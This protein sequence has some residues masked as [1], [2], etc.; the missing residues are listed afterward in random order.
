[1]SNITD[2]ELIAITNLTRLRLEFAILTRIKPGTTSEMEPHT[3]FSLLEQEYNSIM[4]NEPVDRAFFDLVNDQTLDAKKTPLYNDVAD[5]KKDAGIIY[6]YF[7]K[8]KNHENPEGEFVTKWR[9][10]YAADMYKMVEDLLNDKITTKGT[11]DINVF[12]STT[13]ETSVY[14]VNTTSAGEFENEREI[15]KIVENKPVEIV[16]HSEKESIEKIVRNIEEAPLMPTRKELEE[17]KEKIYKISVVINVIS[18]A[19]IIPIPVKLLNKKTTLMVLRLTIK[20]YIVAGST[21]LLAV[22][23]AIMEASGNLGTGVILLLWTEV[24]FKYN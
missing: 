8:W 1:M 24:A 16:D 10:L 4:N 5:L 7:E 6:E 23:Q 21:A 17:L 20:D 19:G 13:G 3:I 2:K 11:N 9:I 15:S 12:N 14:T 22:K 18:L